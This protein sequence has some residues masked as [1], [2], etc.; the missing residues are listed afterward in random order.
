MSLLSQTDLEEY[1]RQ[2][3]MQRHRYEDALQHSKQGTCDESVAATN[4]GIDEAM[5]GNAAIAQVPY[6]VEGQ[7]SATCIV[8]LLEIPADPSVP[9]D[10]NLL[11]IEVTEYLTQES[12][13]ESDWQTLTHTPSA[14][15]VR[16]RPSYPVTYSAP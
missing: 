3:T 7:Q 6:C 5:N 9:G 16:K 10:E 2:C 15:S 13:Q 4:A 14:K 11:W 12:S 1:A 8:N